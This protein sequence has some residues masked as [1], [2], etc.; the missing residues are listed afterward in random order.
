VAVAERPV[1]ASMAEQTGRQARDGGRGDTERVDAAMAEVAA[2]G[3]AEVHAYPRPGP[4]VRQVV[5][6]DRHDDEGSQVEVA[7][8]EADGTLRISGHDEGPRV[9]A[10]FGA[11]IT[12]YDW[13]YVIPATRVDRL[14]EALGGDHGGNALALLAAWYGQLDGQLGPVLRHPEVRAEFSNWHR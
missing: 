6:R 14:V 8:L 7:V 4:A 1:E 5:L 2:A 11:G 9:S 3:G 12:S 13:V 10:F